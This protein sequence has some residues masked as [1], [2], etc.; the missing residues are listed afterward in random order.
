MEIDQIQVFIGVLWKNYATQNSEFS[1][2]TRLNLLKFDRN[3]VQVI[4]S[5]VTLLM[6]LQLLKFCWLLELKIEDFKFSINFV[7]VFSLECNSTKISPAMVEIPRAGTCLTARVR[8]AL[9]IIFNLLIFL[10][11][12]R[13][14]VHKWSSTIRKWFPNF[15]NSAENSNGL[16]V[17]EIQTK[18][19]CTE[20]NP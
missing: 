9:P 7:C 10:I 11:F 20:F 16:K 19:F 2:K 17:V 18:Y 8:I 6:Y 14:S 3:V 5:F 15:S 12:S 1:M 13:E 4:C